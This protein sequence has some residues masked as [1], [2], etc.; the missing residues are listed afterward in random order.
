MYVILM[1]I[2]SIRLSSMARLLSFFLSAV[3][4]VNSILYSVQPY[5]LSSIRGSKSYSVSSCP[6]HPIKHPASHAVHHSDRGDKRDKKGCCPCSF[7]CIRRS[8]FAFHIPSVNLS[9][10]RCITYLSQF[11]EGDYLGDFPRNLSIR[12]PPIP[13][14]TVS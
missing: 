14:D 9:I 2:R 3:L 7:C 10:D 12:S 4:S 6:F 11:D 8:P 1:R 5:Q 13:L